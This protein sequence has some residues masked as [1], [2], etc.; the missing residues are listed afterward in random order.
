M[1]KKIF[2]L[3]EEEFNINSTKQLGSILFEKLK[4]PHKKKN[5][6]GGYSTN[7]EVLEQLA[8]ENYKIASLILQWREITKLKNTYT[9]SL[10]INI[11]SKTNRIHTTFQMAGAQT[12]RL[13][14]SDPNLQNIPI[15]TEKGRKIRK[16]FALEGW[17]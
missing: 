3:A 14:S 5:K 6:S 2:L 4:L 16:S 17:A 10:I 15:K 1:Q 13:S 11:H 8:D 9:D 7:S 12:G